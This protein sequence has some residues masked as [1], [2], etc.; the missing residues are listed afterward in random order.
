M[1][2]INEVNEIQITY[3][4]RPAI[5]YKAICSSIEVN[6]VL[7]MIF[8]EN[9][10]ALKEFFYV[11]LLNQANGILGYF[12]L[13]EGGITS[14]PVDVRGIF[15]V[16]LKA[17]A[18]GVLVAHNHPSGRTVPSAGDKAVTEKIKKAGAF[19]DIRLIDHL[20]IGNDGKD[21]FSFAD[22]GIL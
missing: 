15:Q 8:P 1:E 17:N 13:S 20:I 4:P 2:T 5:K 6:E 16:A 7:T 3:N 10:I 9:Q 22:N 19:L 21:Y 14:T 12:R 11:L 18:T